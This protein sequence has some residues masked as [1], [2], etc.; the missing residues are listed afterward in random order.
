MTKIL[1]NLIFF[2]LDPPFLDKSFVQNL[3]L[4]KSKR[5]FNKKHI[6]IIHR[7]NKISDYLDNL[8]DIISIKKYGRSKIIFGTFK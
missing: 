2:F 7:E 5:L 1:K 4:I 3:E 6:V 8:L